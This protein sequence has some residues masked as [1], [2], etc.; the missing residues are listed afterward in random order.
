MAQNFFGKD[1]MVWWIGQV[2]DPEKGKWDDSTECYRTKTGENIFTWR[3]RVRIVGYHDNADD[4][5]DED[6]PMA[7]V[8][9][10]PGK[11]TTGGQGMTMEYQGGEVVVGFFADGDDAQQPIVFGTLYKQEYQ[12]DQ[13]TEGMFNKKNQVDFVPWTPPKVVEKM[14]PHQINEASV[15][16]SPVFRTMSIIN[17]SI[18]DKAVSVA[19]DQKIQNRVPCEGNEVARIKLA[20][21][22]FK[23]KIESLKTIAEF[24][25]HIDPTFGTTFNMDEEVKLVTGKIHDATTAI[26]RRARAYTVQETLGKLKTT[27]QAATPKTL[28][29]VTGEATQT[30]ID[31]VFCNFEK[32]Q[33]GLTDY[34]ADSLK[35]M[36]GQ[37]LDVPQCAVEN[38]LGDMFGQ[39]GNILDSSM[40]DL[41]GSL[42][43]VTGASFGLPSDLFDKGVM[44][45]DMAIEVLE[46]DAMKCPEPTTFSSRSGTFTGITDDMS[47]ILANAALSRL[48]LPTL[49]GTESPDCSTNIKKC[50]PPKISFMGG[51]GKGVSAKAVVNTLGK[52]IGASIF[53]GGFGFKSPPIM[54]FVDNCDNGYGSSGFPM[55]GPVSA[56]QNGDNVGINQSGGIPLHD[57]NGCPV[58]AGGSGGIQVT[59]SD[60]QNVTANGLPVKACAS[61]GLAVTAGGLGGMPAQTQTC[62]LVVGGSGGIPVM[63]GDMPLT[64]G[65]FPITCGGAS[66]ANGVYVPDPNGLELGVTDIV[67]VDPGSSFLPNTVET[68]IVDGQIVTKEVKPNPDESYD[69]ETSYVTQLDKVII[70]N[71]GMG[72]SDDDTVTVEGGA[73]VNLIIQDGFIVKA[74]V[75]TGGSGFTDLPNISINSDTGIGGRLLP[76]LKFIKVA[77]AK[78]KASETPTNVKLVTV[79]DCVQQ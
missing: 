40:G 52:I 21:T 59:T 29:G 23:D 1:P 11:S 57:Q 45:A 19:G 36:A 63:V 35:N 69:G 32:I 25:K 34:L 24:D 18:T 41:F 77:D 73:A 50:G 6:L 16:N 72:Y 66:E 67:I 60:G 54:T 47:G 30:I 3:C 14:A 78:K 43:N 76:V 5:P 15:A 79:I 28:Q 65:E 38:F 7:H 58:V 53:N 13:V 56:I 75:T 27:L 31:S 64:L 61:G 42:G 49:A 33:D 74:D 48:N 39:I 68:S 26:V 37:M 55:M 46:C 8:L 9:L 20:M 4:L 22:E 17:K 71:A 2:T 44:F 62:T 10:P 70:K 51:G 12:S